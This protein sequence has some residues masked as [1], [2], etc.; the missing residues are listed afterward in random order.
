VTI[1]KL[2]SGRWR[3]QIRRRGARV[4]KTVA[5]RRE[6]ELLLRWRRHP[7]RKASHSLGSGEAIS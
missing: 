5:T 3:V 4:D 2:P 1:I 6:A 7:A